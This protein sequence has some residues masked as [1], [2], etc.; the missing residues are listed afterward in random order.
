MRG[1]H[2]RPDIDVANE[3]CDRKI[4]A[5]RQKVAAIKTDHERWEERHAMLRKIDGYQM[6][7]S[8]LAEVW[9]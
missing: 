1:T 3:I 2:T 5:L 6:A 4:A 9:S 8:V 7:K